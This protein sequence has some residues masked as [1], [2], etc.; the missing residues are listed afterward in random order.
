M[1]VKTKYGTFELDGERLLS[2]VERELSRAL[3]PVV[4][5]AV[6]I[7]TDDLL[8]WFYKG[9]TPQIHISWSD[10]EFK[11]VP[12]LDMIKDEVDDE[13][14]YPQEDEEWKLTA[15]KLREIA[16]YIDVKVKR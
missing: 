6:K 13:N 16:D 3:V 9:K 5:E 8:V 7:Q 12:L 11:D 2:A 1:E 14:E 4:E 15:K 10:E